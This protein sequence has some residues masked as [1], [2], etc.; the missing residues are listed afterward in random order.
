K[1]L[2]EY[3]KT[4]AEG[5]QPSR[6]GEEYDKG[7]HVAP[8]KEEFLAAVESL[9]KEHYPQGPDSV[10][11]PSDNPQE[12]VDA[13]YETAPDPQVADENR[14]PDADTTGPEGGEKVLKEKIASLSDG[15]L[16]KKY[17]KAVTGLLEELAM[18]NPEYLK[19]V[20]NPHL[21]AA[22]FVAKVQAQAEFDAG[23]VA[24]YLHTQTKRA[25]AAEEDPS[26]AVDAPPAGGV[27]EIQA[28]AAVDPDSALKFLQDIGISDQDLVEILAEIV[29]E[30]PDVI[31]AIVESSDNPDLKALA[32]GEPE[33]IQRALQSNPDLAQAVKEIL[34]KVQ[35]G[36]EA[37]FDEIV[38]GASPKD[39]KG[40]AEDAAEGI[41]DD[42]AAAAEDQSDKESES[43]EEPESDE[44]PESDEGLAEEASEEE[45]KASNLQHLS[46]LDKT[47]Q[48]MNL[49]PEDVVLLARGGSREG[50]AIKVA[51]AVRVYRQ[52]YKP[53]LNKAA[54]RHTPPELRSFLRQY[55]Y[56][57]LNS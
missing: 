54:D 5:D 9:L 25:A 38:G 2:Q 57:L 32:A 47:L 17:A 23:L 34:A 7:K 30:H 1:L 48:E 10:E 19:Y 4:A 33:A 41:V 35:P 13:V 43:D 14:E 6:M 27:E 28:Q 16:L 39:D 51:N 26:K 55:L 18:Y 44:D 46:A 50:E 24:G 52:R 20:D 42:V 12:Q 29:K 11:G 3:T 15:E 37:S 40:G 31:Q 36:A 8:E 45:V 53:A 49:T 22:A 21:K 56:E